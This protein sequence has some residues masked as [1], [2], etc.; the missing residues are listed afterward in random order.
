MFNV[1]EVCRRAEE[2]TEKAQELKTKIKMSTKNTSPFM[3]F[4]K[5][6]ANSS[7]APRADT[8]DTI[9]LPSFALADS[10]SP[11]DIP[12]APA[13]S[14]YSIGSLSA[15]GTISDREETPSVAQAAVH[16]ALLE[17]FWSYKQRFLQPTGETKS[18]F[19]AA[20]G[21]LDTRKWDD[22][23]GEM[24]WKIVIEV[25]V[26]RFEAWWKVVGRE[27]EAAKWDE[28][29]READRWEPK[30]G[31]GR[32]L[33]ELPAEMLPPIDV[34]MVWHSFMLN[35]RCYYD[36]CFALGLPGMLA[37]AF[38]WKAIVGILFL[39]NMNLRA[40]HLNRK[41]LL[42]RRRSSIRYPLK[43]KHSSEC[44]PH[45]TPTYS[46]SS[47]QNHSR[48]PDFHHSKSLAR[49]AIMNTK[50][51]SPPT[52][53]SP[54]PGTTLHYSSL[55]LAPSPLRMTRFAP[56]GCDKI[57]NRCFQVVLG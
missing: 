8:D 54:R 12:L 32:N 39:R 57:L 33:T 25:A 29:E 4:F 53:Q 11:D 10:S 41:M 46:A 15:A 34:L 49:D 16:L 55:V 18:F 7:K 52:K 2:A 48:N 45:K 6:R 20:L 22:A 24:L 17:V 36:D 51:Q 56:N 3:Q 1:P 38:P 35:P 21:W 47:K 44:L 9:P 43:P 40:H 27:V 42:T 37:V 23:D 31:P 50:F 26:G 28:R 5:P 14:V 19:G 30:N 13:S